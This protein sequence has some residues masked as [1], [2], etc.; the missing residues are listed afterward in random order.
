MNV[1]VIGYSSLVRRRILPA[2]VSLPQIGE[3]YLASRRVISEDSIPTKNRGGIIQ[4]YAK[5]LDQ[6]TPC[7]A[8]VSLPNSLH[9]EWVYRALEAGFHVI[10]DKPAVTDLSDVKPLVDLAQSKN[11]CLAEANVWYYHPLVQTVKSIVHA[12]E[13]SPTTALCIFSS[14]RVEPPTV[15][16]N[17]ELGGGVLFDRGCTGSPFPDD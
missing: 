16:Y 15:H 4:G 12:E 2:L 17:A 13:S 7:L 14:P 8:Y 9:A 10:V 1:L 11:L 3:I 5:A 6:C